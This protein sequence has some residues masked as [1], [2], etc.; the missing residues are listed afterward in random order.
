MASKLNKILLLGDFMLNDFYYGN[1]KNIAKDAPIPVVNVEKKDSI[2]GGSGLITRICKKF[3]LDIMPIGIV[4]NDNDGLW[5]KNQ[6]LK[7]KIPSKGIVVD[8]KRHT[9]VISKVFSNKV[10]ISRFD[11]IDS[12]IIQKNYEDK[13]LKLIKKESNNC[14]IIVI[15]DYGFG[16]ISIKLINEVISIAKKKGLKLLISSVGENYLN[17]KNSDA[18]IK[19]NL[20]N[21]LQLINEPDKNKLNIK[22][23]LKKLN[24]LLGC[25]KIL[26]TL[27]KDGIAIFD[28]GEIT[29]IP[30]INKIDEVKYESRDIFVTGE[31]MIAS[32][33]MNLS[34]NNNFLDACE[35]GNLAAGIATINLDVESITKKDIKIAKKAYDAW[36]EQK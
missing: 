4:G 3:D 10:Q 11:Q 23:I 14:K 13:L 25:S 21:S 15:S 30:A 7:F 22:Q 26:L 29:E 24:I 16:T 17:Y 5:I 27:G 1:T 12:Q 35:I 32:M 31:I 28:D 20:S 18:M 33:L 8:T 36:L 19:I 2:L 6:L 9:S 34:S